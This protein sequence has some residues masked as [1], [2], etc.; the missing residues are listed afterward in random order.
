MAPFYINGTTGIS[1]VYGSAATPALQGSDTNTGISF[2]SD[3]VAISTNGLQRA[4]VDS[5]GRLLVGVASATAN[6]G[7]IQV[8]NGVTFP[9]TQLDCSDA[10]TLD[11]YEEGTWAPVVQGSSTAGTAT[12]TNQQG[13]YTK[14]GR[15][16]HVQAYIDWNNGS[17]GAGSLRIS[18]LPFVASS[19]VVYPAMAIGEISNIALPAN[20]FPTMRVTINSAIIE[21]NAGP[22][23]GGPVSAVSWDPVGYVVFGG[24]YIV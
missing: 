6:G 7:V 20:T 12:Y 22:V 17:G 9:A 18:G 11:D 15:V 16:V 14:V 13:R 4:S 1:G 23:G 8:S 2:G 10:N 3:T 5:S 19:A 24:S 21:I